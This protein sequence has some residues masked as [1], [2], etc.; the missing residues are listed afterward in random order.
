MSSAEHIAKDQ[1]TGRCPPAVTA[2]PAGR[3]LRRQRRG[4]VRLVRLLLPRGLLRGQ[5]FPEGAGNSLVPL[6]STFAVFAVGFFMRPVGGLLMG[7]VADRRGRRAALTV[8]S[9]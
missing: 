1:A 5:V 4:V 6:L 7:A 8:P 3:R 2:A 9:C